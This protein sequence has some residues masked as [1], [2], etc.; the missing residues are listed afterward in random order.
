MVLVTGSPVWWARNRKAAS[1]RFALFGVS[2]GCGGIIAGYGL[3]LAADVVGNPATTVMVGT[4]G[5]AA[6]FEVVRG[7][8]PAVCIR[9]QVPS[10]LKG[11]SI[12]GPSLYGALLGAAILTLIRSR[13][14]YLYVAGILLVGSPLMG[15]VAGAAYGFSYAAAVLVLG[16]RESASA[17][18]MALAGHV[19][20]AIERIRRPASA[21]AVVAAAL[22][23]FG[24]T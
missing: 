2:A 10:R 11:T 12:L 17:D 14:V 23:A 20:G 4:L 24:P 13:L 21:V 18:P 5:A 7:R 6:A 19:L 16:R 8:S 1:A 3:G 22:L 15:A 9:R